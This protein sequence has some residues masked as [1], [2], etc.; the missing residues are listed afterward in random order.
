MIE[1]SAFAAQQYASVKVRE[2]PKRRFSPERGP[3]QV[4]P[5]E[6]RHVL[7]HPRSSSFSGV[8]TP[9]PVFDMR[10]PA[11]TQPPRFTSLLRNVDCDEGHR[12][13]FECVTTTAAET[14]VAI[15]WLV[16]IVN[17]D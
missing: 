15:E 4:E 6:L 3:E 9:S 16:T 1:A 17:Y 5:V 7:K 14:D 8:V 11:P 2:A 12:A 10:S 13:R